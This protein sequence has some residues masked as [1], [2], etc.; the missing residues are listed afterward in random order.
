M[1]VALLVIVAEGE[2]RKRREEG[3]TKEGGKGM[4]EGRG[5]GWIAVMLAEWEGSRRGRKRKR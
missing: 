1:F 5:R 3:G 4:E 2:R